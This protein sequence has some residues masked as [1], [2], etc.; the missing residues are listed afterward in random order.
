M[1]LRHLYSEILSE[2]QRLVLR[3][4]GSITNRYGFYMAGG[5]GV[6]L[7]L[8]HRISIDMDWFCADKFPEPFKL[9]EDLKKGNLS[10]KT[11]F[12]SKDTLHIEIEDVKVSFFFYPYPLV[13]PLVLL[14]DFGCHIASLEDMGCM[15]LISISQRG[16]KRDFFDIYAIIKGGLTLEGLLELT[17]KK[18][19]LNDVSS[20]VFGLTY[21]DDADKEPDPELLWGIEW[22]QVKDG[23]R[24]I[25]KELLNQ[26]FKGQISS[27]LK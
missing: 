3:S 1:S 14:R 11:N 4:L 15:K 18:Y 10:L 17:K 21:F 5:T 13:R 2:K 7:Y 8:G 9:I 20:I 23:L 6:A 26:P 25:T 12:F 24:N 22:E 19:G 27:T 16:S